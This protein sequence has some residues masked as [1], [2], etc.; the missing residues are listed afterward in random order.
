MS[1]EKKTKSIEI[2]RIATPE[3][4]V[5]LVD[6][7]IEAF[8]IIINK[9]TNMNKRYKENLKLLGTNDLSG[10]TADLDV[11]KNEIID[12]KGKIEKNTES[13]NDLKNKLADIDDIV[14]KLED[15][16]AKA[17]DENGELKIE[18]T[19]TVDGDSNY[20]VKELENITQS[21]RESIEDIRYGSKE[22]KPSELK[23]IYKHI[24]PED[25]I[26]S[27]ENLGGYQENK[28]ILLSKGRIIKLPKQVFDFDSKI[29][30]YGPSGNGKT[31]MIRAMAKE[32][33]LNIIELN[34][35]LL[36]SNPI[37]KQIEL[38]DIL[39]KWIKNEEN[40]T[41]CVFLI[42]NLEIIDDY[43]NSLT[44][45]IILS[46]ILDQINLA[47]D[48]ILVVCTMKDFELVENSLI[49]RFDYLCEFPLPDQIQRSDIF[50]K[51]LKNFEL[52]ED[53][54]LD[55]VVSNLSSDEKTMG[56]TCRD[57]IKII[58]NAYFRVIKEGRDSMNK[59]DLYSAYQRVLKQKSKVS[60][61]KPGSTRF[62]GEIPEVKTSSEALK[63]LES[64]LDSLNSQIIMNKKIIK[65]ALRLALSD[66]YE[67]INRLV[68]LFET[69]NKA[70]D[71]EEIK[72]FS[73]IGLEKLKKILN[74]EPFNIIFPK[75][76]GK[77]TI[78][79]TKETYN[80]IITEFELRS[81]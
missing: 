81:D 11:A 26:I 14:G 73:G 34:L 22:E 54:D 39:L 80:E 38:L 2:K 64:R 42:E 46:R 69:E 74:K 49:S 66:E 76:R 68:K 65:N 7:V 17:T 31:A 57:I 72:R 13:T 71:L 56:F 18:L 37:K 43:S 44:L 35:P 5:P 25:I 48:R 33:E 16:I 53:L 59:I 12:L 24:K 45:I 23:E 15:F 20:L 52:E 50:Y 79:F 32:L 10:I 51:Q 21:F 9:M 77:Y 28:D 63:E 41:P 19:N 55:L 36:L 40:I 4:D 1:N 47:K 30:L 67:L 6:G 70:L 8:N 27:L 78:S 60:P 61:K 62:Q 75:I 58:E 3:G 29:L